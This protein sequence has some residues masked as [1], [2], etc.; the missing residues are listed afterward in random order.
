MQMKDMAVHDSYNSELGCNEKPSNYLVGCEKDGRTSD[1]MMLIIDILEYVA[2][3]DL[4][5]LTKH[6]DP[7]KDTRRLVLLS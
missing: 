3:P 5:D 2:L 7:F 1:C 6:V 4:N